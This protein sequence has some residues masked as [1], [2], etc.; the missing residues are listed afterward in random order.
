MLYL[1]PAYVAPV[2]RRAPA[3]MVRTG[4][5]ALAAPA[6]V[7]GLASTAGAAVFFALYAAASGAFSYALYTGSWIFTSKHPIWGTIFA[8]NTMGAIW[9]AGDVLIKSNE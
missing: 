1:R 7:G 4:G 9:T 6:S 8:L 5:E 3:P 2:V